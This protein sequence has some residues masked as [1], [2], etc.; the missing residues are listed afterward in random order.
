MSTGCSAI[1]AGEM[2]PDLDAPSHFRLRVRASPTLRPI[3]ASRSAY[4]ASDVIVGIGD[5]IR[6]SH[7]V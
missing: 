6:K 5:K 1:V 3:R 4:P 7:G 2:S